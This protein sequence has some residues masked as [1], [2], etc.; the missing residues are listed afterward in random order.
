MKHGEGRS[1]D[2][3]GRPSLFRVPHIVLGNRPRITRSKRRRGRWR[4][5]CGADLP[6]PQAL[7]DV[8]QCERCGRIWTYG[9]HHARVEESGGDNVFTVRHKATGEIREVAAVSAAEA[10]ALCS[11]RRDAAEV[12]NDEH[13]GASWAAAS[14]LL[15]IAREDDDPETLA[16][17]GK[18]ARQLLAIVAERDVV[19]ES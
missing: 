5:K 4:C 15:M 18:A 8:V 1:R 3:K 9:Y 10:C 14:I 7:G 19:E 12:T 17:I 2:A 16:Y 13:K 11:W 6:T